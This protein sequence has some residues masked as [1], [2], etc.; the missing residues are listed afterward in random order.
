MDDLRLLLAR[1]Y[2][3]IQLRFVQPLRWYDTVRFRPSLEA[4]ELFPKMFAGKTK[5]QFAS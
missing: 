3:P 5:S 4:P 1:G 2:L